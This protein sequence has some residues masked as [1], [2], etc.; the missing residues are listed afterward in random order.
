MLKIIIIPGQPVSKLRARD[1]IRPNGKKFKF[2]PAKT[3][4]WEEV[5][6]LEG[7]RVFGGKPIPKGT[8]VK[9]SCEFF[10]RLPKSHFKYPGVETLTSHLVKPDTSNLVKL[11][12]D[13]LNGIAYADDSQIYCITDTYKWYCSIT[14]NNPRTTVTIYW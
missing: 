8:P 5:V 4:A 13:A 14:N 2:S 11:V 7:L 12:E 10:F 1:G 9:I 3:K 6:A